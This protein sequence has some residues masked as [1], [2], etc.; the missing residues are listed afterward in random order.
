MTE[1]AGKI[2]LSRL[3]SC[4][5]LLFCA[6][7]V[8]AGTEDLRTGD[9]LQPQGLKHAGIYDLKELDPTLD[10]TGVK[11]GVI[12]RVFTYLADEPQNDY[13][14]AIE[15]SCF[16][17]APFTF[18]DSAELPPG[19][20]PHSTAIC[21]I[22]FGEDPT[23]FHPKLGQ[24][25]YEGAVP[26]ATANIYEFE[27][28]LFNNVSR[29]LRPDEDIIAASIG[30][31]FEDWGTRG[32]EALAEHYGTIVVAGIGN[33]DD[34][35]HPVL[36][37]GAG[38]NVIGVG[39][40]DSVNSDDPA[41]NLAHFA[42][43]YPEHSSF[44]P[45]A[46][47]RSK[48]DIVAPGNCLAAGLND[49]DGYEATGDWSSF[50]TPVVAGAVGLLV[51]KAKQDPALGSAVS[52]E[53]GNCV[54]KAILLNSATKLPYWH[55]G[56]LQSDDDHIA[57]LDHIQGAGM[58]NAAGAYE[59]LVAGHMKPGDVLTT[60][61]DLNVLTES[62]NPGYIY[63]ITL[64][65]PTDGFV[66]ATIAWN[67]HFER[68]FPFEPLPEKDGNLR[69]ELWAV[70]PADHDNDYLLDY[71]DSPVDNVEHIHVAAD[72]N[73][74]D[75][76]IFVSFSSIDQQQEPKANQLY[77]LA[78]TV[79]EKQETDNILWYDLNADGIVNDLDIIEALNNL[80]NSDK[81][82]NS[83]LLGD[84]NPDGAID[85]KDLGELLNQTKNNRRADWHVQQENKSG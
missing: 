64:A 53:G 68:D 43:A 80:S 21:S 12:C 5:V 54:I 36:Y 42:L 46:N 23:A 85:A 83:Y 72:P 44:G 17:N 52:A 25:Y 28:F 15:H 82:P 59:H 29:H 30:S 13:R 73:Y 51:Q 4:I 81:L 40:V 22:L 58:L 38:G 6:A 56:R 20:S 18:Y 2:R 62:E 55:K 9:S 84:I 74:T 39:V 78:W 14:P 63:R 71:S 47:G 79:S 34:A 33:G 67:R 50:S 8:V 10:G 1:R 11:F 49:P 3:T 75:Y 48:P 76:E 70:D 61:W 45:T 31:P 26:K 32:I 60:G 77:A 27:H 41:T 35:S 65:E 57:P 7:G 37:P 19:A 16:T 69:I 66:T 24:F